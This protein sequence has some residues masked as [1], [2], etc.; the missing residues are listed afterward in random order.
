MQGDDGIHTVL[1]QMH[2]NNPYNHAGVWDNSG[3]S[4]NYTTSMSCISLPSLCFHRV[5]LL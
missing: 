5:N 1:I 2:Y 4:F 3:L